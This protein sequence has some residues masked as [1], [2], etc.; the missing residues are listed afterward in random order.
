[1]YSTKKETKNIYYDPI[2]YVNKSDPAAR[3][4]SV[5]CGLNELQEWEKN[6]NYNL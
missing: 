3:G 6:I 5:I 4:L 1:L 2:S